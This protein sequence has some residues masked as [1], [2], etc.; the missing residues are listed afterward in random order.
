MRSF[1]G[2][3]RMAPVTLKSPVSRDDRQNQSR[4]PVLPFLLRVRNHLSLSIDLPEKGKDRLETWV[5]VE[6]AESSW[7]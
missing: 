4:F 3:P 6:L 2:G 5:S 1:E 7:C